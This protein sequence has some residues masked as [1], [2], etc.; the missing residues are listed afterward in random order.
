MNSLKKAFF[1]FLSF[2]IFSVALCAQSS[3]LRGISL[4]DYLYDFF[5][6]FDF[7]VEKQNIIAPGDNK[8]PYNLVM[9]FDNQNSYDNNN[10][11][12]CLKMDSAHRHQE[13]I[14][15]LISQLRFRKINSTVLFV[16]ESDTPTL[17]IVTASGNDSFL[18]N[19]DTD[20]KYTALI[21]NL[22]SDKNTIQAGAEGQNSPSWLINATYDAYLDER[23]SQ[24]LPVY[25]LS[26]ISKLK[27]NSNEIFGSFAEENIP[28]IS[29]G[30]NLNTTPS[31]TVSRVI[32]NFLDYYAADKNQDCDYHSLMFRLGSKKIWLSEYH[33]I[34]VLIII[35]F[36]SLVFV[37]ILAYLSSS[38]KSVAWKDLR[39]SWYTIPVT[40]ILIIL[41]SYLAKFIYLACTKQG[42][43][44]TTAFGLPVLQ[45]I[46][47]S[48]LVS[49][50]YL[51]EVVFHKK[52]YGE[53]SIDI[54]IIITTFLNLCLFSL[55]DISLFPLFLF[56]CF[57]SIISFLAHRNWLHIVFFI[58]FIVIYIPYI[59]LLYSSSNVVSLK[60]YF[61]STS[62]FI[63][64][65]AIAGLPI[66]LMW[67][68]ILT[69]IQQK[70]SRNRIFII[71]I[72]SAY[73]GFMI[74]FMIL[75]KAA[76]SNKSATTTITEL[77]KIEDTQNKYVKIHYEDKQI[78]E[79]IYRTVY[80]ELDDKAVC[81]QV[82]IVGT[83]GAPVLYSENYYIQSN[84][85]SAIF[86]V[87]IFP[88]EKLTFSYGANKA[89]QTIEAKVLVNDGG[90]QA[91]YT[92]SIT[93]G[94]N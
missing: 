84:A 27:Y 38:I 59:S 17:G 19:L 32:S 87:P 4:C 70:H 54:L 78:F 1:A 92:K 34:K 82:N 81:T 52:S 6:E 60:E 13:V 29:A 35:T 74:I 47:A 72:S 65:I 9:H 83:E 26:Q 14:F 21:L 45:I 25:Y 93:A 33:I 20:K 15:D 40:L 63:Y 30:F 91:I 90:K 39:K 12:I 11:I 73:V 79:N 66:Y 36:L 46:I 18:S 10:L 7:E 64:V 23:L 58:V 16:Y 56:I 28:I 85:N 69:A 55:V 62:I 24:D 31:E 89:P 3:N 51:L 49:G 80:L 43:T 94:E 75:N 61:A 71:L 5:S 67:L 50:F 88:P 77:E 68:R 86:T 76:Y 22:D 48:A 44:A 2:S 41:G 53:R 57:C 42:T 8:L 37:Y